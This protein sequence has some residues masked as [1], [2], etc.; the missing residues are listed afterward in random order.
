METKKMK[1]AKDPFLFCKYITHNRNSIVIF[2]HFVTIDGWATS[3]RNSSI[4]CT[5]V[6]SIHKVKIKYIIIVSPPTQRWIGKNKDGVQSLNDTINVQ[7][8]IRNKIIIHGNQT[9]FRHYVR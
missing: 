9:T 8:R 7:H 1:R 4:I 2:S 6:F 5:A 3:P